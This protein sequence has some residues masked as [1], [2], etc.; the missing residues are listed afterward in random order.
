MI[1]SDLNAALAMRRLVKLE[2]RFPGELAM[3][4][5]PF[6]VSERLTIVQQFWDFHDEGWALIRLEDLTGVVRDE[7]VEFMETILRRENL[8][9]RN[10][11]FTVD[12]SSITA[13]IRSVQAARL[14]VIVECESPERDDE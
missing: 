8:P 13:A 9:P 11:P 4:G 6:A 12:L 1:R 14:P 10:P 7:R 3:N 2:R 5:Y